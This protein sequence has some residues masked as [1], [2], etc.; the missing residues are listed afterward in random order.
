MEFLSDNSLGVVALVILLFAL[1]LSFGFE[2]VNGFHD[3]ANAV[4][5][6]GAL[7]TSPRIGFLGAAATLALAR[8]LIKDPDLY[9]A[10]TDGT[11]PPR[12]VRSVLLLTCTGV[13]FAHGSND[14]QKGMGLIMLILI[15][16]VPATYALHLPLAADQLQ[17]IAVAS[18]PP[19]PTS[20]RPP[21]PIPP[22]LAT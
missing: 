14:G 17:G 2:F 9:R 22:H 3:T 1:V 11:P 13:S 6:V 8:L 12:A 19:H 5:T 7:V 21:A 4:E 16:L 15:G 20:S 18:K 10:P